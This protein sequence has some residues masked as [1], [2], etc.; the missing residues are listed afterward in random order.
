VCCVCVMCVCVCVCVCVCLCV[1]FACV[2]VHVCV[3][4]CAKHVISLMCKWRGCNH[5]GN[6]KWGRAHVRPA[7]T[8]HLAVVFYNTHGYLPP[9]RRVCPVVMVVCTSV[10]CAFVRHLCACA[11]IWARLFCVHLCAICACIWAR[12]FCVH[13]CTCV[14]I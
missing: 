8:T 14:C 2:C 11:C 6:K 1:L 5:A 7:I 10:L 12:L 9:Y 3:C 4:M 13:L